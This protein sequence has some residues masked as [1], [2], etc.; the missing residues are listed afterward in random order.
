MKFATVTK[1]AADSSLP[2]LLALATRFVTPV[3][4]TAFLVGAAGSGVLRRLAQGPC[5]TDALAAELGVDGDRQLLRS[6]LELGVRLGELAVDDGR[7]RLKS[8]T[9]QSLA[10]PGN[11]AVTA[12]LEEVVRFHIPVLRDAPAMLQDGRRLTLADQDGAIIARS[13]RVVQPFVE[14][15]MERVLDR[16]APLRLLE[17]GC[18]SGVYVRH[19]A[20]LNPRLTAL[21]IDVQ[22]EV[23]ATAAANM[24]AWGLSDRVEVRAADVREM[25]L[26]P[27]FDLVTMHNNIYYFPV[28]ERTELLK[29]TR[30]LLAPGGRLLLTT[31][32]RGGN[33]S[34][35]VLNL[36]FEFADFGG[37][38]PESAELAEQ[39]RAAGFGAVEVRRLIPG[40]QFCAVVG[41]NVSAESDSVQEHSR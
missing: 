27:Q 36:W 18:G 12:A 33:L 1:L 11:D 6:W 38:L 2:L 26:E 20:T 35:E 37:P 10:R 25:H 34:M 32:C 28:A 8:R 41:R 15:A 16:K 3:Y 13:S 40:E 24:A 9:A 19:A 5:D 29:H 23:A 17:I 21:A 30:S 31:S 22:P 14:E 39:L 7:Y 4:R